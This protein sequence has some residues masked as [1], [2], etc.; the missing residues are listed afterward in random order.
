[1]LIAVAAADSADT[2][3]RKGLR[4][5]EKKSLKGQEPG[6][7]SRKLQSCFERQGSDCTEDCNENWACYRLKGDCTCGYWQGCNCGSGGTLDAC[8]VADPH[9]DAML[10][11]SCPHSP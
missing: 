5:Q 2:G 4:G 1:M 7:V 8:W 11:D 3:A 10:K 9:P 6:G